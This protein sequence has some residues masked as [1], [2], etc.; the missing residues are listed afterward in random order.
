MKRAIFALALAALVLPVARN[1]EAEV[2]VSVDFFYNNLNSGGSW[3]ELG[4]YGYCWQPEVAVS[5][6]SWRPYAD[7]SWAYTDVGWTWVSNEPFG[8]AT[9]HYGRWARVAGVGWVWV[10]GREWAP[11]WV[12]WRTGGDY[13]G[14]APLPP[15]FS[16]GGGE[17]VY[18]GR[19]IVGPVDVEFDIGPAYYNFVNVQ[20]IGEPSLRSRIYAP[21]QNITY[22]N[23]TVNV[24]NITYNN[25]TVYNYG[26][27]YNR[28]SSY[29]ARPIRRLKLQ[30]EANVDYNVAAQSGS[31][32]KVQGD[33]LVVAAPMTLQKPAQPIAPKALKQ[34]I[35][36]PKLENGWSG[37]TDPKAKAAL[38]E[39]MKKED[40]KAVPPPTGKPRN[41]AAANAANADDPSAAT[42]AAAPNPPAAQPD[43]PPAG[44]R[45]G[46]GK[47]K[48]NAATPAVDAN[49]T[50]DPAAITPAPSPANGGAKQQRGNK[51]KN[52][53]QNGAKQP[54]A[55]TPAADAAGAATSPAPTAQ[56][57]GNGKNDK[58]N[59]PGEQQAPNDRTGA[60]GAA[61]PAAGAPPAAAAGKHNNKAD[62][63][64]K[65]PT[66][67][68]APA[69]EAPVAAA[70]RGAPA[71]AKGH[72]NGKVKAN[73]DAA[74]PP[75]NGSAGAGANRPASAPP[76]REPHVKPATTPDAAPLN[77]GKNDR[78]AGPNAPQ[79]QAPAPRPA[80]QAQRPAPHPA[81]PQ[82]A[83]PRPAGQPAAP[84][85]PRPG[86]KPDKA[87]KKKKGDQ[88]SPA[89][90]Q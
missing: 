83:P 80:P 16:G 78:G 30:R 73:H 22:I 9:Y 2:D 33:S 5:D 18:E 89:S 84:T 15:R 58:V 52:D 82:T 8:W 60:A 76:K 49:A 37:V 85:A 77:R 67:S 1:A 54:V 66:A 28:L 26:P 51:G 11:A 7:G 27:D 57:G 74:V 55:A 35:A 19:P 31:A 24:T 20:Y 41:P 43:N 50:G 53:K 38:Q 29:S 72:G 69:L 25:T 32:T 70:D 68:S 39:K 81:P 71:A 64:A 44:A 63:P 79:P 75:A 36:Q 45:G 3:V 14:W 4:D 86:G 46:K 23:R 90:A 59:K 88:P 34:K 6:T 13:V 42:A 47:N 62:H 21:T 48:A 10:P 40:A 17:V 87:E 56:P 61:Q 65:A 12:S